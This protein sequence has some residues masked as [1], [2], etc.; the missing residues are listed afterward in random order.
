MQN[1]HH[2]TVAACL[3]LI[4]ATAN[5]QSPKDRDTVAGSTIARYCAAW[6]T[7]DPQ[8]RE[9][10]LA[11]VWSENGEYVDP[12]PVRVSGREALNTEILRFQKE[13]P[14]SG[15]RCGEA[16]IHHG[17]VRYAWAMV[18]PDGKDRFQ[19]MDFGELDAAG[20]IV[21]VVSFFGV[22]PAPSK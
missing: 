18:G 16:Q 5:A 9:S 2:S 1:L 13:N 7:T 19:G 14:G 22:A 11:G 15:F 6:S 12:Q 3:A 8:A 4:S 21:R 17:F 10:L 20:R